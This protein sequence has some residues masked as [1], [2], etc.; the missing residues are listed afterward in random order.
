MFEAE[1][2]IDKVIIRSGLFTVKRHRR[3][4]TGL[5]QSWTGSRCCHHDVQAM[6]GRRRTR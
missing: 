2:A 4:G 1:I 6:Y 3:Q 5:G